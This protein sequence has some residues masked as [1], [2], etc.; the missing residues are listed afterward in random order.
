MV[1]TEGMISTDNQQIRGIR[2]NRLC[3]AVCLMMISIWVGFMPIEVRGYAGRND[4]HQSGIS[5]S[6][7]IQA[8]GPNVTV[9]DNGPTV[10]L[11]NGIV[12]VTIVKSSAR[13]TN[14]TYKGTNML[15][16]G[17]KGGKIYWSWNMP[18]YQNPVG[19]TYTLTADPHSN[20]GDYAEVKLHM[21]WN[22]SSS[23]AAMDVDIY[24]SL[25]RG[26]HGIYAS[27][28]LSHP[29][30][31]PANPGGEFRM[32]SY[33]GS[34][35]DWLSVDSL[36]NRRMATEYDWQNG[37]VPS[38][39]PKEVRLLHTGIYANHYECKYDYSADFGKLNVWGWSSTTRDVGIWITAPSKEY[40]NGGPMKREL[41]GHV[42]PTLLNMLNGQHYGMGDDGAI[43][44]GESW[45]KI[46]GPFLIYCNSVPS[47][48]S[49]APY[50]LWAA[51]KSQAKKEQA[52]WPYTWYTN[53]YYV[54][55]S[56]RGTITGRLVIDDPT[57]HSP[58]SANMWVGAAIQPKS[59]SGIK[60]FQLWSKNYQFW[61]KTD[62][63]GNFTIPH[64]LPGT[65]NLY[66]FGPGAAGQ[67]TKAAYAKVTPG[68]TTSLGDVVWKPERMAP[69][70]WKIG[71]PDRTA[72]EFRHGKNWWTSNVYPDTH[73][74]KFMDY[75]SEFPNGVNFTIGKSSPATDWNFV[76]Y[77]N[78]SVQA[79]A[80]EWKVNFTLTKDPPPDSTAALYVAYAANFSDA[81]I[82][83]VNGT[84]ITNPSTGIYPPN[85]SDAMIRKGIHGAF[86]DHR[87]TFPAS[88]LHAGDNQIILTL[89]ITGNNLYGEIMYDYV[90]LE[91]WGTSIV[92]TSIENHGSGEPSHFSLYQN[93]PNPFNPSTIISYSLEKPEH[94]SLIVY[95]ILGR[96]VATLVA[97]RQNAGRYHVR[98]NASEL[99]SGLYLYRLVAGDRAITRRMTLIK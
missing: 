57:V 75:P 42:G 5:T 55:Q 26:A 63:D 49:N 76:Q 44:A 23:T 53:P 71:I 7:S 89:R 68:N 59:V 27:A 11:N 51:A 67:M 30:S 22:G 24:Y 14:L 81:S 84:N 80:P 33:V 94:A 1:G 41:T 28:M 72:S 85:P 6:G 34:S 12:S 52:A 15:K 97:A 43:A 20:N 74:G 47:G 50:A 79:A 31:Y 39:A 56:G 73:W 16:G 21:S 62:A 3:G 32:A 58:S 45:R 36:R 9:T 82:I 66:A 38:G 48:T 91:A 64:V 25:P 40:Y 95:D 93:Y 70:V 17:Y 37:T 96:K 60:D 86:G 87:F 61:V 88:L 13:I 92:T 54:K 18:D 78:R 99:A 98:F 69:T 90:R 35:F 10:V 8:S 2:K 4:F 83:K 46:Y 19:C 77:Y 65:Y 29:A